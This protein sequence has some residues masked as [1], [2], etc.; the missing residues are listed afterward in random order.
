MRT[1][2]FIGVVIIFLISTSCATHYSWCTP[3]GRAGYFKQDESRCQFE[4]RSRKTNYYSTYTNPQGFGYVIPTGSNAE[5]LYVYCMQSMGYRQI[6]MQTTSCAVSGNSS[7]K[8]EADRYFNSGLTITLQQ[9][10]TSTG[11]MHT[12]SLSD[13]IRP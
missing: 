4:A 3:T 8:N 5:Q 9:T 10:P 1:I 13:T 7:Y 11:G 2:K 12:M 6:S